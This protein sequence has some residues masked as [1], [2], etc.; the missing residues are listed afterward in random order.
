MRTLSF[1]AQALALLS[2][3]FQVHPNTSSSSSRH[4][5]SFSSSS[6]NV[7][8]A[9]GAEATLAQFFAAVTAPFVEYQRR[10]GALE[11]E[12]AWAAAEALLDQMAP[13]QAG[14]GNVS[15]QAPTQ[16]A[17]ESSATS[18]P[19]AASTADA[20]AVAAASSDAAAEPAAVST[21]LG[22]AAPAVGAGAGGATA[23]D[24]K[25]AAVER[26][27]AQVS[28]VCRFAPEALTCASSMTRRYMFCIDVVRDQY[29]RN[30]KESR[31]PI[32]LPLPSLFLKPILHFLLHPPSSSFQLRGLHGRRSSGCSGGDVSVF[33]VPLRAA[34]GAALERGAQACRGARRV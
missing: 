23:M 30:R 31:L 9:A 22:P 10:Y 1:A 25:Q 26:F 15:P 5:G 6:S 20:T 17:A 3:G 16:V 27:E 21:S 7:V 8:F 28:T 12:H 34:P 24:S 33:P 2:P 11:E 29:A 13:S 19:A 18:A 32:F 4:S 14:A